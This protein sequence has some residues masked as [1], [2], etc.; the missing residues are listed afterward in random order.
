MHDRHSC[1]W[2]HGYYSTQHVSYQHYIIC[3]CGP[4]DFLTNHDSHTFDACRF[5]EADDMHS[6]AIRLVGDSEAA[7]FL[8]RGDHFLH[9]AGLRRQQAQFVEAQKL[10]QQATADAHRDASQLQAIELETAFL[11]IDTGQIELG[12][13]M[14]CSLIDECDDDDGLLLEARNSLGWLHFCQHEWVEALEQYELAAGMLDRFA[15]GGVDLEMAISFA[16]AAAAQM[17]L[18]SAA[19][20]P[21]YEERAT[22][23]LHRF[24]YLQADGVQIAKFC[25]GNCKMLQGCS[26][27][28]A[29][30][31]E[32]AYQVQCKVHAVDH[33]GNAFFLAECQQRVS[34]QQRTSISLIANAIGGC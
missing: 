32:D 16:G 22:M 23:F 15:D 14:L 25:L 28:A 27:E 13:K 10:L 8:E 26:E 20:K 1:K 31:F 9:L 2:M 30:L 18:P 3:R 4:N 29:V 19:R 17:Y 6:Q 21:V 11:A 5:K 34:V 33:P 7:W 24:R 12:T